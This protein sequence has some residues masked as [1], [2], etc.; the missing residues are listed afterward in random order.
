MNSE[1][2]AVIIATIALLAVAVMAGAAGATIAT[3]RA[4]VD[5]LRVEQA[6]DRASLTA[7]R[8]AVRRLEH[9]GSTLDDDP[10]SEPPIGFRPP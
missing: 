7:V 9:A 10:E 8:A 2:A 1:A 3:L 5:A 6:R 4:A